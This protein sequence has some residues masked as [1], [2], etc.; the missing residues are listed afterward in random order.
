VL[1]QAAL[2]VDR[3]AEPLAVAAAAA[4]TALLEG[5]TVFSCGLGPDRAVAVGAAD[6]LMLGADAERPPLPA[7][8]ITGC[9]EGATLRR[10]L[11]ALAGPGDMAI[12][13][14]SGEEGLCLA[15]T[16]A[17]AQPAEI[18]LVVVCRERHAPPRDAGIICIALPDAPRSRLLVLET[19][20]ASCLCHLIEVNLFGGS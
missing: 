4:T 13:F 7:L 19:M 9:D 20:A 17:G 18:P 15:A 16:V 5:G 14:D 1:E 11:R 12:C 8:A 3:M 10:E 2:S 6:R